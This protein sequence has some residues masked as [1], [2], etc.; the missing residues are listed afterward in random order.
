MLISLDFPHVY[1]CS[2]CLLFLPCCLLIIL[3][4]LSS[5]CALTPTDSLSYYNAIEVSRS[6][7]LLVYSF[8]S[9]C[10]P[11]PS[12]TCFLILSRSFQSPFGLCS[13]LRLSRE[14]VWLIGRIECDEEDLWSHLQCLF[15]STH[16]ISSNLLPNSIIRLCSQLH[17]FLYCFLIC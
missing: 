12:P 4:I 13:S 3:S 11:R 5:I 2:T 15:V 6:L 17:L 8:I 10:F 14:L 16:L 7:P 9:S 1:F